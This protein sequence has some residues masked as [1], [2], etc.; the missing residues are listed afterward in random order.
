M[1]QRM[2]GTWRSSTSRT[3]WSIAGWPGLPGLAG[4]GQTLRMLVEQTLKELV[5][6]RVRVIKV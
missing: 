2:A 1:L 5:D 4:A 3:R 6:E